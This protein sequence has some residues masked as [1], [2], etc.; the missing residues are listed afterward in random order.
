LVGSKPTSSSPEGAHRELEFWSG[1]DGLHQY[2]R[3]R[4]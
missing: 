1:A 4:P 3:L 2:Q